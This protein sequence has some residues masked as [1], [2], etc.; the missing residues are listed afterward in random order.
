MVEMYCPSCGHHLS[1]DNQYIGRVGACKHCGT[2]F[3]VPEKGDIPPATLR[4]IAP[5]KDP[6]DAATE[7]DPEEA[8]VTAWQ[9]DTEAPGLASIDDLTLDTDDVSAGLA[10]TALMDAPP[11]LLS[12][13]SLPDLTGSPEDLDI[14]ADPFFSPNPATT[15]PNADAPAGD[16][17]G[18][19]KRLVFVLVCVLGAIGAVTIAVS[20][21]GG[22]GVEP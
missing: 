22:S 17:R 11:D 15:E 20:I 14:A 7:R 3:T 1:I 2:E 5:Y 16:S 10:E 12:D 21:L 9:P 6:S 18:W 13:V 4:G 8:A 19:G